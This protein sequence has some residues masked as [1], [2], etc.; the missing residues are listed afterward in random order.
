MA[1]KV[2]VSYSTKDFLI[3]NFLRSLLA[4][5]PV[6]VFVAGY[7]VPPGGPLSPLIISNIKGC[8]LFILLWSKNSM[9]SEWVP[10]EIGIAKSDSKQILPVLLQ[11]GLTLTGFI[12]DLKYLEAPKDPQPLSRG[13]EITFTRGLMRNRSK[14]SSHG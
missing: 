10:Q 13:Y 7:D 11:S 4:S 3:V 12:R 2:F 14:R 8:G 9:Q 1:L 6:A 5:A